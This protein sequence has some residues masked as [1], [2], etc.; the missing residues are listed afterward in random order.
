MPNTPSRHRPATAPCTPIVPQEARLREML[1]PDTVCAYEAMRAAEV[2]LKA[3][4]VNHLQALTAVARHEP[5][6]WQAAI[7]QLAELNPKVG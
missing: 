2:R 7:R 1:R 6:R 4:G 5:D 3:L